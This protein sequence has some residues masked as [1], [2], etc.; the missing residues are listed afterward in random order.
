MSASN[1]D[2]ASPQRVA[3]PNSQQMADMIKAFWIS[4]IVGTFAQLGIPDRLAGGA[5]TAGEL[6]RL[7]ACHD[8]A[9]HRLMRAAMELGLVACTPDG[10]FNLTALGETLRSD[11]PGSMRDAAIAFT[12]PGHWLPWGR[13]S[14][15]V[16]TGRRQTPETLGAELFQYYSDNPS[17]G[18]AFTGAMSVSSVQVADEI[19]RVL[20]TSS[21][22]LVVDVGGASGALIA[23]L[24]VKNPTLAGMILDRPDVAPRARA[25]VA[26]HGLSSR[27]RVVEGNFFEA[28]PEAD[29]HLLKHIIHD[30][31]D[32]Q[33]IRILCNCAR[34]LRPQG[35][36]VLVER[37][38]AEDDRQSQ[39]SL[40]DLNMLVLLPGRE[41]TAQEYIG[42]IA[43][44][45]LRLDRII[46]SASPV[47]VI[48]ASAA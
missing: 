34:A 30:W 40:L 33:S 41:R 43:R 2:A 26:Q 47:S 24:L 3:D 19:A 6:V 18:C 15:A 45:G 28:V 13:L 17:E 20:D 5:L 39:T 7:I 21:A 37:V 27:C 16:R 8:G 9:T 32:E 48:E 11:V 14:D 29:I 31:D 23:A 35:R 46:S 12:A 44:A 42:L 22:R 38:M 4:Q 10:R 36:V 1:C 25:A